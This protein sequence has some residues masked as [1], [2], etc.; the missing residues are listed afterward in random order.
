VID[1]ETTLL[2]QFLNIAQR[3]RIAK[4][5]AD[6]TKDDAGFGLPPLEDRRSGYHFAIVS[7]HQSATSKVA[8]HP[9]KEYRHELPADVAH[10]IWLFLQFADSLVPGSADRSAL[11]HCKSLRPK[12]GLRENLYG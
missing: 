10:A 4:I 1:I 2:Q 11:I 3:K 6:G 9:S 12:Q 8:T 7:L 5:P